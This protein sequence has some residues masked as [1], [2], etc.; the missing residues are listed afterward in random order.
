M[1]FNQLPSELSEEIFD[2]A[3]D[4]WMINLLEGLY[5]KTQMDYQPTGSPEVLTNVETDEFITQPESYTKESLNDIFD[6]ANKLED[7]CCKNM[8][9]LDILGYVDDWVWQC[10]VWPLLGHGNPSRAN[11]ELI[12][13]ALLWGKDCSEH[14][15]RAEREYVILCDGTQLSNLPAVKVYSSFVRQGQAS[16]RGMNDSEMLDGQGAWVHVYPELGPMSGIMDERCFVFPA[17]RQIGL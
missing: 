16:D 7:L 13:H 14:N 12:E 6:I 4:S 5:Q 8:L 1:Q 9:H 15:H 17:K 11:L 3:R 2:M 10:V